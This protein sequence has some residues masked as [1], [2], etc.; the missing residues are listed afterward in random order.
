MRQ[1]LHAEFAWPLPL[2]TPSPLHALRMQYEGGEPC[3]TCGHVITQHERKHCETVLPTA[4]IP[5][6]LYLGSYDTASRSEILKAMAIT[7]I[8]NVSLGGHWVDTVPR[9]SCTHLD[10]RRPKDGVLLSLPA[11]SQT[12]PTCE[13]L[14]K[15][16][17]QYHTVSCTPPDF[18][19]CFDFIG[20]LQMPFGKANLIGQADLHRRYTYALLNQYACLCLR[21]ALCLHCQTLSTNSQRTARSWCTA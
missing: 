15:N 10:T 7:H 11:Q 9:R 6:F 12:V 16:T 4:I 20:E 5:G 3:A 13:A 14:Y 19:E 17:F 21:I 18:Q 8:L 1:I 2:M